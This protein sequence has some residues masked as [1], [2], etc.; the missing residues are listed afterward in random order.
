MIVADR[1]QVQVYKRQDARWEARYIKGYKQDGK[2]VLGSV[3]GKTREEAIRK[4]KIILGENDIQTKP[5]RL[6]LLILG[7]GS[8]ACLIFVFK[9][10]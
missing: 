1:N 5:D 2:A 4:R 10:Q 9:K 8:H 3:Y 6:N 7:A